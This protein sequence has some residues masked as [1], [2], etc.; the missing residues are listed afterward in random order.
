MKNRVVL[1][2]LAVIGMFVGIVLFF[3]SFSQSFSS[4]ELTLI[5]SLNGLCLIYILRYISAC[6][7]LLG[8]LCLACIVILKKNVKAI[9]ELLFLL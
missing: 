3:I 1:T 4:A 6:F 7:V 2:A 9:A 8:V 5:D